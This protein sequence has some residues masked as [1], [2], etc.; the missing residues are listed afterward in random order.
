MNA[1]CKTLALLGCF[2]VLGHSWGQTDSTETKPQKEK[3]EPIRW[4]TFND[5]P[6]SP[7]KASV[8]SAVIPGLGQAYNRKYWKLPIVYG[9]LVGGTYFMLNNRSKMRDMNA[10]FRQTYAS[11]GEPTTEDISKRN[12]YR[13]NRDIAILVVTAV[14]ALQIVDATVDAH[15]FNVDLN[16]NLNVAVKPSNQFLKLSYSF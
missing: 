3:K 4:F 16:E 13:Q 10:Q 5:N 6:H 8:Y 9:A 14:Y 11:G 2:F 7:T 1:F 12:G 15:F